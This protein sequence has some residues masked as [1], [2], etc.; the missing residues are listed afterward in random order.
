MIHE[1]LK[2]PKVSIILPIRNEEKFIARCLSAIVAQ[3]YPVEK[4]EVLVVDGNSDDLTRDVIKKFSESNSNYDIQLFEN[5]EKIF[6]T[7]FNIGLKKSSGQVI[8]ILGGHTEI[9]SDYVSNCISALNETDADCV[10][11]AMETIAETITGKIIATAMSSPFGVGGVTFRMKKN[12]IEE[13]SEVVFGAYRR[14]IIYNVG[15]MDEELIRNQDDEFNYRI[16]K[17]NGKMFIVPYIRS[18]YYSRGTFGSLFRQYFQYGLWKV[19]VL[20]KHPAQMRS[21]QFIPFLFVL[22]LFLS[23]I[24]ALLTHWGWILL[25]AYIGFYLF[26]NLFASII[27]SWKAGGSVSVPGLMLAFSILHFS[28]GFGFII[29]LF[30]F[31]NRWQDKKGKTP[32]WNISM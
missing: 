13:V 11:G 6:P 28:Y 4:L 19:R 1:I 25:V 31:W 17:Y 22:F 5:P 21:R 8:V 23:G 9:S 14:S 32:G 2:F 7:G 18:R 30:K 3:D 26:V 27:A 24:F 12:K 29:G 20:Q 15:P 10:G 16:R